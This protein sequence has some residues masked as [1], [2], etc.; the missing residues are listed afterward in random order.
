MQGTVFHIDLHFCYIYGDTNS[1]LHY[2]LVAPSDWNSGYYE[3][4][5]KIMDI[6]TGILH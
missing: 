4:D 5:L 2:S 1:S 6:L 3:S